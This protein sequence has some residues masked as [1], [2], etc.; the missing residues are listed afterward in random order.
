[1]AQMTIDRVTK[2][3][4][5]IPAAT[6]DATQSAIS[7]ESPAMRAFREK[8]DRELA[9]MLAREEADRA[10]ERQRVE[11]ESRRVA[12]AEAAE[13]RQREIAAEAVR[14]GRE[15][16]RQELA[17]AAAEY[18]LLCKQDASATQ[19]A[20]PPLVSSLFTA[21]DSGPS[22]IPQQPH[23][24]PTVSSQEPMPDAT[25]SVPA[26]SQASIPPATTSIPATPASVPQEVPPAC[27]PVELNAEADFFELLARMKRSMRRGGA[28]GIPDRVFVELSSVLSRAARGQLERAGSVPSAPIEIVEGPED[29]QAQSRK[30]QRTVPPPPPPYALPSPFGPGLHEN[31]E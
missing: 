14:A 21:S 11:E 4:S 5:S 16:R 27:G 12:T 1:M 29:T 31:T 25:P 22:S 20:T 3:T 30:R 18:E 19:A 23:P 13:R 26:S 17:A 15:R 2:R 10:A 7:Q 6:H 28:G 9:E 24:T 8:Q